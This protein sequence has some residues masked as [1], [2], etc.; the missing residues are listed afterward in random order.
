MSTPKYAVVQEWIKS[1]I[2]KG[3]YKNG[4]KMLS[5]NELM[6]KFNFSRQTI[7]LAISNLENQGYLEK[8]KGSGT[9]VRIKGNNSTKETR[10][11]GV[12]ITYLDEYIF[13][14]I[15]KG[16]EN[17]LSENNYNIT[18]GI[19]YNKVEKETSI[20]NSLI[21]KKVDGIIVEGTKS[22]IP[23]P[24]KEIYAQLKKNIPCV[25]INGGYPEV[26]IP[27]CSMN[28]VEGGYIAANYLIERGHKKIGAVFKSDDMPGH[29]RYEGFMNAMHRY[30]IPIDEKNI[31]WYTT[32]D[33]EFLFKGEADNILLKRFEGCTGIVCYNDQMALNIIR[34]LERNN[35]KPFE[36][37]SVIGFD[38][39]TLSKF[40]DLTSVE[41]MKYDLG[42]LA[43][44][45]L[46]K[47]IKTGEKIGAKIKPEI[48]ERSS[49]KDLRK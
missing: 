35:I 19:T 28:D 5:E 44:E 14:E 37:V 45:S 11:I 27:L 2:N 43:A 20:L 16:I 40:L 32:E 1:E 24:N 33:L 6:E 42:A 30:N 12:I 4:E 36:D 9:Y 38:N 31:L 47:Q 17:V 10:N 25:F 26:D 21:N 23:N 29:K 46:I 13:P 34:F 18:L 3:T 49:V 22:A 15:I 41:H 7:R 39:S 48:I 8:I